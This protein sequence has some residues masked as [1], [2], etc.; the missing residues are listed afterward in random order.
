MFSLE[1]MNWKKCLKKL[2]ES[3]IYSPILL[4]WQAFGQ[5]I[6]LVLQYFFFNVAS[7]IFGVQIPDSFIKVFPRQPVVG[8][9]V[10]L[11][12]FAYGR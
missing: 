4:I 8:S 5:K 3:N 10:K 2:W 9:D 11:E 1:K 12:C 7:G 6:N